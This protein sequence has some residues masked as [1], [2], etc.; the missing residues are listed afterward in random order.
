MLSNKV[1]LVC[2]LLRGS[3]VVVG[4]KCYIIGKYY[5]YNEWDIVFIIEYFIEFFLIKI[6][7]VD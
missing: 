6:I 5:F 2:F 4:L 7:I 3:S 1:N